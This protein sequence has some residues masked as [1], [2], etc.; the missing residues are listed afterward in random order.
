M[1]SARVDSRSEERL[2]SGL[3]LAARAG[4]VRV[5]MD[6]VGQSIRRDEAKAIVIAGDAPE[7]VRKRVERI[8]AQSGLSHR[9]VLD[10]DRLG[11]ALGRPRVVVIAVTDA[12]LGRH[13]LELA[14]D[15]DS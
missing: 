2:L 14:E 12:A 4:R 3:G 10:G 9:V 11:H 1:A 13:V 6:A 15:V 7:P 5:G 8:V